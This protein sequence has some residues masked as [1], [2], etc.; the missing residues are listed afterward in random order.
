MA[1]AILTR[2]TGG[3]KVIASL[4]E[5]YIAI[6]NVDN[7]QVELVTQSSPLYVSI[8]DQHIQYDTN[9]EY[10]QNL[11]ATTW[12][13]NHNLG[14]YCSVTV[15]DTNNDVIFGEVHYNSPNQIVL[16]FTAAFSGKAYLN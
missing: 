7:A 13:I 1:D 9:F 14:K 2:I 5:D 11:A 6:K 8:Q 3:S 10:T 12:T 4:E 15:V 16:T